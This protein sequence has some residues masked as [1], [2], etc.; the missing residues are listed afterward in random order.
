MKIGNRG[1]ISGEQACTG[2]FAGKMLA[3]MSRGF[4]LLV[5][6]MVGFITSHLAHAQYQVPQPM[7]TAVWTVILT[8]APTPAST[9][10]PPVSPT[11]P[12][13]ATPTPTR[14]ATRTP[15]ATP[16]P[17]RASTRTPT[18]TPTPTRT[19]TPML[20][21]TPTPTPTPNTCPTR[22][23]CPDAC[24]TVHIQ[25]SSRGQTVRCP[26]CVFREG[27]GACTL[28]V[29]S[30]TFPIVTYADLCDKT[31]SITEFSNTIRKI[32]LVIGEVIDDVLKSPRDTPGQKLNFASDMVL[33]LCALFD[34]YDHLKNKYPCHQST[35]CDEFNSTDSQMRCLYRN[36]KHFGK[37][38]KTLET[39]EGV[40][41]FRPTA[42]LFC[43]QMLSVN[44]LYANESCMC[45]S[46]KLSCDRMTP[47]GCATC[48][49]NKCTDLDQFVHTLPSFCARF[50]VKDRRDIARQSC[51][52]IYKGTDLH[53]CKHYQAPR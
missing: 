6:G 3:C 38:L 34:E 28:H 50:L 39:Q 36:R 16:T 30:E 12:P 25:C 46:S 48:K 2:S 47:A 37:A 29:D 31:M 26:M 14:A 33:H 49:R 27:K 20:T 41:L 18:A 1:E 19:P 17:T 40:N 5:A 4:V 44:I 23:E 53:T 32:E 45:E 8:S 21:R 52:Q 9:V 42:T 35:A 24:K 43:I 7:T 15:T 13:T 10:S 51:E 22:R 11:R